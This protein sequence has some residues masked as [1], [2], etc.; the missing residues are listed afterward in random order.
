MRTIN[1]LRY[2]VQRAYVIAQ[3]RT[4]IQRY[5]E[6]FKCTLKL[7]IRCIGADIELVNITDL[8][9]GVCKPLGSFQAIND[10]SDYSQVGPLHPCYRIL[11]EDG[12]VS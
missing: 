7:F 11:E 3:C 5:V 12:L 2:V 4:A 9:G 6:S 8:K 1:S 10:I